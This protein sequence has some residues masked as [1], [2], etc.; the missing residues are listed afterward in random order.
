M[1]R[2]LVQGLL[3]CTA[4]S[5][6]VRL[7]VIQNK[8]SRMDRYGFAAVSSSQRQGQQVLCVIV[9]VVRDDHIGHLCLFCN[10]QCSRYRAC[11]KSYMIV[12]EKSAQSRTLCFSVV[13]P[14]DTNLQFT[15]PFRPLRTD[16]TIL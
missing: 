12:N 1:I 11:I 2:N 16:G 6:Q 14:K 15:A 4:E 5:Q 7:K 10:G 8:L 13:T 3:N 9:M